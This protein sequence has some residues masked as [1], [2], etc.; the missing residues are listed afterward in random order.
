MKIFQT[1]AE[2]V[3]G[4]SSV[5]L[6]LAQGFFQ[7]VTLQ[8][9]HPRRERSWIRPALVFLTHSA[10][11]PVLT[12]TVDDVMGLRGSGGDHNMAQK[13]NKNDPITTLIS[14]GNFRKRQK[15]TD[16]SKPMIYR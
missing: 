2:R 3:D 14:F 11:S 1:S 7:L 10:T 4:T 15:K 13:Q 16:R 6:N 5:D 9:V 8:L 12:V